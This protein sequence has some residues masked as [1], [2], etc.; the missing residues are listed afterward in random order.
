MPPLELAFEF[1]VVLLV[2]RPAVEAEFRD[3]PRGAIV[4]LGLPSLMAA[5]FVDSVAVDDGPLA[6]GLLS[7]Y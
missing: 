6:G 3:P 1:S 5:S 4:G 2:S 7:Q